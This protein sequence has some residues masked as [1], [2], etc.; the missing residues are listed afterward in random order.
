MRGVDQLESTVNQQS[1]VICTK[2]DRIHGGGVDALCRVT[3]DNLIYL[4]EIKEKGWHSKLLRAMSQIRISIEIL[5]KSNQIS[6]GKSYIT[7]FI[8]A[9]EIPRK[10]PSDVE[11]FL[12][13]TLNEYAS[14]H[15]LILICSCTFIQE[16]RSC[17]CD[18]KNI[19]DDKI[20]TILNT[21]YR[22]EDP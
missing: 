21:A 4:V 19:S 6:E 9:E 18:H 17:V 8:L 16:N 14:Y 2:F 5:K 13:Q 3:N 22:L 11:S 7:A 1:R 20:I 10:I 12:T 15:L